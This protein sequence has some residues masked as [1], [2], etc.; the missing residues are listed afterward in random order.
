M[1]L[2]GITYSQQPHNPYA[3]TGPLPES[4]DHENTWAGLIASET[5][6]DL[7]AMGHTVRVGPDTDTYRSNVAFYEKN[8]DIVLGHEVHTNA[9]GTPGAVRFGAMVGYVSPKGKQAA[10]AITRRVVAMKFPGGCYS[11]DSIR[12]AVMFT[13][14]VITLGEYGFHDNP[15]QAD[16]IRTHYAD[17]ARAVALGMHDYAPGDAVPLSYPT[18]R[19]PASTAPSW[20][21]RPPL[22]VDGIK[23]PKT[24]AAIQLVC[25]DRYGLGTTVDGIVG[26][27]TYSHMKKAYNKRN[28]TN[29][30]TSRYPL[31]ETWVKLFQKMLG[32]PQDG[33]FGK[34]TTRALQTMLNAGTF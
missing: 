5:V 31:N 30:A 3:G 2:F 13:P 29:Y 14:P 11:T 6:N 26:P 10:D 19:P 27:E 23:G 24:W 20:I 9:T 25:R 34:Q 4:E 32:V 16:Y 22:I 28:G 21:P 15:V 33:L 8:T 18:P 17:I 7:R 12:V 1:S